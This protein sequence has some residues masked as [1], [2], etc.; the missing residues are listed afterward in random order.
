MVLLSQLHKISK[1]HLRFLMPEMEHAD[2]YLPPP[3]ICSFP[4]L[5]QASKGKHHHSTYSGIKS[6]HPLWVLS[7]ALRILCVS[8]SYWLNRPHI[9][10]S[11]QLHCHLLVQATLIT[12]MYHCSGLLTGPLLRGRSLSLWVYLLHYISES[13]LLS[14]CI[15]SHHSK[16]PKSQWIPISLRVKICQTLIIFLVYLLPLSPL[17]T[18]FP[19]H[20]NFFAVLWLL[21]R[22][23]CFSLRAF[24]HAIASTWNLLSVNVQRLTPLPYIPKWHLFKNICFKC[25]T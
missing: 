1:K 20:I 22:S 12:H 15:R 19:S 4:S 13:N 16:A 2:F 14:T 8:K 25:Q 6:G 3:Y 10:S 24:A 5:S 11:H 7:F 23:R 9:S 18:L 21:N 17:V